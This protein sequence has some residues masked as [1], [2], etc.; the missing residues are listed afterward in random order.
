MKK[1][2]DVASAGP[3]FSSGGWPEQGMDACVRAVGR[4]AG[5]VDASRMY[6][7]PVFRCADLRASQPYLRQAI[8]EHELRWAG[9]EVDVALFAMQAR[10]LRLLLLRYGPEVEVEPLHFDDFSLVQV[11]L[12]GETEIDCDGQRQRL[13]P[14]Q[15]ALVCPRKRLRVLWSRGCEQLIIR[16]PNALL[17]HAAAGAE[18]WVGRERGGAGMPAPL[19]LV[20]GASSR[21]WNAL[22]GSIIDIAADRGTAAEAHPAWQDYHELGM[23][24]FL[25]TLRGGD[26]GAHRAAV[27]APRAACA[28]LPLGAGCARGDLAPAVERYV[29][30]RICAP[31]ALEDLARAA[32]VSP[33]TLHLHW[34]RQYGVGPMAWL[35]NLRLDIARQRL[36]GLGDASITDVALECGFGHLG[37][38]SAYYRERFGE[39]PRET[40]AGRARISA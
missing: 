23:A 19:T 38:F 32:G 1:L 15:S 29:R 7:H 10:Q 30:A 24:V 5:V 9:G 21:T 16:V 4:G 18:A 34:K 39:L 35:R 37:R 22:L 40:T 31:I 12:R 27:P 8:A 33:R 17:R 20:D 11:P 26:D 6:G 25:H 13:V 36:R 2:A 14:G 28:P 3:G